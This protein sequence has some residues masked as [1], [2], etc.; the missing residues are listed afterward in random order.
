MSLITLA[1]E[2]DIEQDTLIA[3]LDSTL[4][5][6]GSEKALAQ[7]ADVTPVFLSYVRQ[8]RRVPRLRVA[9]KVAR[10]LP[11]PTEEQE[12]WLYHVERFWNLKQRAQATMPRAFHEQPGQEV[13]DE[14]RHAHNRATFAPDGA[15]ARA[16]YRGVREAA[17]L[18]LKSMNP[19]QDPI[20]YVELC[21]VMHDALCILNRNDEALWYAKRG[22]LVA[23][24][25]EPV[26]Y[27]GMQD[28]IAFNQVNAF[29][30]EAIALHNLKL[31]QAALKLYEQA[32]ASEGMKRN[33]QFWRLWLNRDKI[34]ALAGMS[35]FSITLVE[36]LA[37]QARRIYEMRAEADDSLMSLLITESLAR[38]Y[39]R[40]ENFKDA[41]RVLRAGFD[42]LY[43]VA[44]IGPL[45]QVMF[46]RTFARFYW[47]QGDRGA[48]WRFFASQGV[49]QAQQAG[50][51]HQL[52][53]MRHEYGT[54]LDELDE[55]LS[56]NS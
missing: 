42:D 24:S 41:S 25:L 34:N 33:D 36:E 54:Q 51:E 18:L 55:E 28:R 35:R 39:I 6:R 44:H 46:L 5:A 21:L 14:V 16:Q 10:A 17:G 30:S 23:E 3:I 22:R 19:N 52:N 29:R 7:K 11:L 9:Q 27:R 48:E 20:N 37:A 43:G 2:W 47:Q 38:A 31:H 49:R 53:E 1:Q 45:H 40:H 13:V 26:E 50:L 56:S 15:T 8:G 12:T 4:R 32:E